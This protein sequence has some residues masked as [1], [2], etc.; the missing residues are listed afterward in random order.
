MTRYRLRQRHEFFQRYSCKWDK[1]SAKLLEFGGGPV[2]IDLISAEPHAAEI[3]LAA[4][5]ENER[6]AIELWRKDKD[7]AH[8]WTSAFKH[9]VCELESKTGDNT[10]RTRQAALRSRLKVISCDITQEHPIGLT[11]ETGPF[12][13]VCSSFCLEVASKTH[14]EYK[15]AIKKLAKLLKLGG[16]LVMLTVEDETFYKVGQYKWPVLPVTLEQVKEALEDAGFFLLK[17]DREPMPIGH[18]QNSANSDE[19]AFVFFVAYKVREK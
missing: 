4:H 15:E 1:T 11:E 14:A 2:I 6:Q 10:W 17:A 18:I 19:K 9:V 12:S 13:V 16:Y 8:D 5:T 3:V 7:G